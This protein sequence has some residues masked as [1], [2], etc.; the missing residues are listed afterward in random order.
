[1][2][3]IWVVEIFSVRG[4]LERGMRGAY[5]YPLLAWEQLH[6]MSE[7]LHVAT[8]A[9]T[10]DEQASQLLGV[11]ELCFLGAEW[12]AYD[13]ASPEHWA[14]LADEVVVVRAIALAREVRGVVVVSCSSC[15]DASTL[16]TASETDTRNW[17]RCMMRNCRF[18]VSEETWRICR[19]RRAFKTATLYWNSFHSPSEVNVRADHMFC[20]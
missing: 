11:C 9:E 18:G 19:H 1:M 20:W 3:D 14:A 16:H 8:A 2:R 6:R 5:S 15:G 10:E 7:G 17:V 12:R 13:W 4:G